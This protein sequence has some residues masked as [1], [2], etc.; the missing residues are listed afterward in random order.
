VLNVDRSNLFA[1]QFLNI[2]SIVTTLD[3][4][5]LEISISSILQ[6]SNMLSMFLTFDVFNL[7]RP[8]VS[9]QNVALRTQAQITVRSMSG[10]LTHHGIGITVPSLIEGFMSAFEENK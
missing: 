1:M 5:S 9:E 3:V 4:S 6:F 10:I 8:I 7:V 2:F